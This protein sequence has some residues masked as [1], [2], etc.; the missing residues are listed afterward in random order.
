MGQGRR[1]RRR[2]RAT[3]GDGAAAAQSGCPSGCILWR[4]C[5]WQGEGWGRTSK[6]LD[7]RAPH[8]EPTWEPGEALRALLSTRKQKQEAIR[9]QTL[10]PAT[11]LSFPPC[12]RAYTAK[13]T[14]TPRDA[15][16]SPATAN[17]DRCD[18]FPKHFPFAF[19]KPLCFVL[20]GFGGSLRG[21]FFFCAQGLKLQF[22]Q[23]SDERSIGEALS[24]TLF[25]KIPLPR[26]QRTHGMKDA[27]AVV[28][29]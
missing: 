15:R 28:L 12:A 1:K 19:P 11:Q 7:G 13:A 25:P 14:S 17:A 18:R 20:E 27:S 10:H 5:A 3:A 6:V 8:A 2:R 9:P 16:R 4:A 26:P 23:L 22:K 29:L 21:L 24:T